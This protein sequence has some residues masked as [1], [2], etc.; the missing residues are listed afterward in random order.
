MTD[1]V[2]V[3]DPGIDDA[4]AFAVAAGHPGCDVTAIV[5]GVG[6]VDARSA[7]RNAVGLVDLFGLDVP[8]GIGAGCALDGSRPPR[9]DDPVHG[10]DGLGGSGGRLAPPAG[11]PADGLPLVRGT[12]VALGPLTDVA[13]ALRAGQPVERV[14]WMGGSLGAGNAT[15]AAEFNAWADADAADEVLTSGIEVAVVP[16]DVTSRVRLTSAD[17]DAWSVGSPAAEFCAGIG[18][19]RMTGG[20]APVHDPVAVIALVEPGLFAWEARPLRCE[21]A[22]GRRGALRTDASDTPRSTVRIATGVDADVVHRRIVRCV[23]RLS[24]R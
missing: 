21:T 2:I 14:V 24:G 5:A 13:R 8:V 10:P 19:Y 22:G 12:V 18:A 6:N 15:A 3:A 7:W 11:E 4:I 20:V 16:L 17:I 9:A 23:A 1:V